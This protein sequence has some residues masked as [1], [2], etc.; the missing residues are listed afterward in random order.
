M[1]D[2]SNEYD[3]DYL[4]DLEI[5]PSEVLDYSISETLAGL[6]AEEKVAF[7]R[8]FYQQAQQM[9]RLFIVS[10]DLRENFDVDVI[11]NRR[12]QDAVYQ[13]TPAGC[14]KDGSCL[15]LQGV[16]DHYTF[17][18]DDSLESRQSLYVPENESA[19]VYELNTEDG[20]I[21]LFALTYQ[22]NS[23]ALDALGFNLKHRQQI[24][25]AGEIDY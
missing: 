7:W 22:Q 4:E 21:D 11:Y 6:N 2:Y 20:F 15:L 5:D 8:S 19:F 23:H 17:S 3:N 24:H 9:H 10:S 13:A 25:H 14:K 16:I 1:T 18:E 12:N